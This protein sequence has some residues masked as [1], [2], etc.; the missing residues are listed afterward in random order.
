M[1]VRYKFYR[2]GIY[3]LQELEIIEDS[4]EKTKAAFEQ[5]KPLWAANDK[6]IG[7]EIERAKEY[8]QALRDKQRSGR[9]RGRPPKTASAEAKQ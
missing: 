7:K 3:L 1:T 9:P 8:S 4:P 2:A 5:M 6:E